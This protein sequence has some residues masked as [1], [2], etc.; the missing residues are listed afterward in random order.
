M[1]IHP[2]RHQLGLASGDGS[3]FLY[4]LVAG[5]TVSMLKGH[6]NAIRSVAFSADGRLLASTSLDK[7]VRVWDIENA[8]EVTLFEGHTAGVRCV[9]FFSGLDARIASAST[10]RTIRICNLTSRK[11]EKVL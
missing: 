9:V 10:D 4:N 2:S 7:T 8:M 1:A 3:V 6:T 11:T 5:H